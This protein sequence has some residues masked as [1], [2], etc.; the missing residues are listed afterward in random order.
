MFRS[1]LIG[2]LNRMF[3]LDDFVVCI[4]FLFDCFSDMHDTDIMVLRIPKKLFCD[5]VVRCD[6]TYESITVK[7]CYVFDWV[8]H[9]LTCTW[10]LEC[11]LME[12]NR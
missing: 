5:T 10:V 6:L 12:A 7:C 9:W 3:V 8:K 11:K 1:I 2:P 4:R